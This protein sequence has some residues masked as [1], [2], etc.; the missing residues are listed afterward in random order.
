MAFFTWPPLSVG[1]AGLATEA[2]QIIQTALLTTMDASLTSLDGK[3]FAT[4]TEQQAQTV[5]LTSLDGKDFATLTEQQ[6]QTALL[7]TIDADTSA[8]AGTVSGSELQ[9]DIV[10]SALPS[11]AATLAEQQSQTALLNTIDADTGGL[12]GTVNTDGGI[13]GSTAIQVGGIAGGDFHRLHVS[14]QGNAGVELRVAI[15]AG[16]NNI[17]DVDVA[18]LPVSY[19]TGA[20]DASTQRVVVA[21]DQILPI[22]QQ[23]KSVVTTVR[24][25]YSSVNVGT[26]TWVELVASLSSAVTELEI[27]DSSGQ[28]LEL[29]IG[30][31]SSETRL[32]LVFPGG[33]GR[34]P[35]AI[36]SGARVSVRAVSATADVGEIDINFYS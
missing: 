27:F 23:G 24:N 25:D 36:A 12:F 4:L 10:S 34:V 21:S 8:L 18:T 7:T 1:A 19:N 28:T 20:A 33:N 6:A 17:G 3:D 2:Q 22:L 15:P 35:V 29:G 31:A 26:V 30:A 14:N 32:I 13:A 16:T 5:L 11:G 9:V